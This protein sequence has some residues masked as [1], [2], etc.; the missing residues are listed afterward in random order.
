MSN[1]NDLPKTVKRTVRYIHQNAPVEK[2]VEIQKVINEAI[3]KRKIK[4]NS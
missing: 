3:I 2:L 4:S 1:F